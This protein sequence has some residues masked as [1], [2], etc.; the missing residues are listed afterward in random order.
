[1][2]Q[3][4]K[5]LDKLKRD[6]QV[7]VPEFCTNTLL[8]HFPDA[9]NIEWN[10]NE[11]KYEVAFYS[12]SLEK[13]ANISNDGVLIDFRIRILPEE[14]PSSIKSIVSRKGEIMSSIMINTG[15]F[16]I[17]E[18]IYRDASLNRFMIE[19]NREGNILKEIKL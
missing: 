4:K 14:I 1:M 10:Q 15:E 5:L 7:A 19:I 2:N 3:F 11:K 12:G 9:T 13:L 17:Y 18:I 8:S 16:E 6:K